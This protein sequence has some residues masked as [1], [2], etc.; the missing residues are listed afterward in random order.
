MS[1]EALEELLCCATQSFSD[2]DN[3]R[4]LD[5]LYHLSCYFSVPSQC[6]AQSYEILQRSPLLS[7]LIEFCDAP[8]LS[9]AM[10]FLTELFLNLMAHFPEFS[11]L[12]GDTEGFE[13]I[14]HLG[15]MC[16]A[17]LKPFV[18]VLTYNFNAHAGPWILEHSTM[19]H[20]HIREIS[21]GLSEQDPSLLYYTS[22]ALLSL[23]R[24]AVVLDDE[25]ISDVIAA[26][27]LLLTNLADEVVDVVM[28]IVYFLFK[29]IVLTD[30]LTDD[31]LE[32][33]F[34]F[35][36]R[37][38]ELVLRVILYAASHMW[39]T[40]QTKTKEIGRL[41]R[42]FPVARICEL[43]ESE[44]SAVCSGALFCLTNFI[45]FNAGN[46]AIALKHLPIGLLVEVLENGSAAAK[47]EA[48]VT[49]SMIL[50]QARADDLPNVVDERVVL[51]LIGAV[52]MGS[53]E[54]FDVVLPALG[55]LMP[56][57]DWLAD[58]LIAEDF[59]GALMS[60]AEEGRLPPHGRILCEQL[61]Q[62]RA[63]TAEAV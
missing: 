29:N 52:E 35:L 1:P 6:T 19:L 62:R 4:F 37:P 60:W 63:E 27:T 20:V 61:G 48:A 21:R 13:K 18:L 57:V 11:V 47:T 40:L 26:L 53:H 8:E 17:E 43:V 38:S 24:S 7:S 16:A 32:A 36:W 59:D 41:Q 2:A 15:A 28:W 14:I 12:F 25:Q 45:C 39:L 54:I 10:G 22:F 42:L 30:F 46:H 44:S 58:F 56:V 55:D 31:F 33:L 51:A 49:L 34:K 3:A 5:C 50:T 9:F 23:V